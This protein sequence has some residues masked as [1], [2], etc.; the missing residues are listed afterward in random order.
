MKKYRI[1]IVERNNGEI[2]YIPLVEDGNVDKYIKYVIN[3]VF[4]NR[5]NVVE[6]LLNFPCE[7]K[8]EEEAL[9]MINKFKA[10]EEEE[11]GKQIK[12]TTYKDIL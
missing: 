2:T 4:G 7:C 10:Q 11:Y 3:P 12:T 8:T 1:K 6:T 5:M 9:T